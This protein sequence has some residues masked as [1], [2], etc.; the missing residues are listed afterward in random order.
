MAMSDS[1]TDSSEHPS[2]IHI[3]PLWVLFAVWLALI[4]LTV[5]TVAVTKVDLGSLNLWLAMAIATVKASL[6]ALF[7]MHLWWDRPFHSV[8]LIGSL[9]FVMLFVGLALMDTMEY[10]PELYQG[11]APMV[12][13]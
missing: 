11:P 13:Q 1:K 6:V 9:I 5:V 7:F 2:L 8:V 4:L 3:A 12:R 10:Q